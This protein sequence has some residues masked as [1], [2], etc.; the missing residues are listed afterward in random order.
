MTSGLPTSKLETALNDVIDVYHEYSEKRP[1][2]DDFLQK[3]EF[4]Q[5]LKQHAKSFLACTIPRGKT[6][7]EYIEDLFKKTDKNK[8]G[9]L[10]FEEF[11][12]TLA[13]LAIHAH[14][15][16]HGACDE[17]SGKPG[18]GHGHGHGHGPN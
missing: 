17:G 16:S 1:N 5:L 11:V 8:N 12:T 10:H 2:S 15:L 13:K 9:Q 7:D 6:E 3:Q 4:K 14:D 18:D